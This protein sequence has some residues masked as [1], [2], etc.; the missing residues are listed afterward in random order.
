MSRLAFDICHVIHF[1]AKM[2][3]SNK[4]GFNNV[5]ECEINKHKIIKRKELLTTHL[6]Q[7]QDI[8]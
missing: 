3:V 8:F 7:F 2:S 6:N 1:V 4:S 5:S